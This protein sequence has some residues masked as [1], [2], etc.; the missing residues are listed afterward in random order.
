VEKRFRN[1]IDIRAFFFKKFSDKQRRKKREKKQRAD[2]YISVGIAITLDAKRRP[3]I[4]AIADID[5]RMVEEVV[6]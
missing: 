1:A 4:H 3:N 5:S 6:Y 2:K